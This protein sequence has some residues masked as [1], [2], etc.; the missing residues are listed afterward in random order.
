MIEDT[1]L[2]SQIDLIAGSRLSFTFAD[3]PFLRRHEE[4]LV[5]L[6]QKNRTPTL[7]QFM[8]ELE[9]RSIQG[10]KVAYLNWLNKLTLSFEFVFDSYPQT[11]WRQIL[12]PFL[13][14]LHVNLFEGWCTPMTL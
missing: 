11:F 7:R 2:D 5:A 14:L 13:S 1:V 8:P 4:L 10:V 3:S 9:E 12:C 6:G